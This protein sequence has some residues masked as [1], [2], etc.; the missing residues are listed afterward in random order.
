[1]KRILVTDGEQRA[2]LAVTRSL[3]SASYEVHVLSYS[4]NSLAGA[5]RWAAQEH[6][7]PDALRHPADYVESVKEIARQQRIDLTFPMTDQACVNL[8]PLRGD[9][10]LVGPSTDAYSLLSDKAKM[11]PMAAR[12]GFKIPQG[13]QVTSWAEAKRFSLRGSWPLVLKPTRSVLSDSERGP[14]QTPPVKIV[15][16]LDELEEAWIEMDGAQGLVQ[17]YVEGWGEG[18]F[19]LRLNGTTWASFAHRRLREKPPSGGVSV[20]R[21]SIPVDARALADLESLLDEVDFDGVAM[22]EFRTDGQDR[23][24]MEFN[25]RFWGSLQLAIDAGVDF[26]SWAV[27]AFGGQ[28]ED[29]K[30]AS[31]YRLGVRSRW[32]IGDLDHAIALARGRADTH[33]RRGIYA[34]LRALFWT[35][36]PSCHWEV[37]RLSDPKPF[38]VEVKQWLA[39]AMNRRGKAD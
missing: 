39:T 37:L 31:G 23:W 7:V 30:K 11:I 8:L 36:G 14:T 1:M 29:F 5:S 17:D 19:V 21:E 32:L 35:A 13:A 27:T 33:G 3:G 34:A 24:L 16:D 15:Q 12:H 25:V 20:L 10:A 26:P 9:L 38:W 28:P 2:S 18:I 22:A 4:R 6:I